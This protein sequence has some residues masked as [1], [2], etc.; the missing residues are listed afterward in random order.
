MR[1]ALEN[2]HLETR[3]RRL[4]HPLRVEH[5]GFMPEKTYWVDWV[6][7]VVAFSLVLSGSGELVVRNRSYKVRAPCVLCELPGMHFRYGPRDSWHEVFF[8]YDAACLP[9]LSQMGLVR[10]GRF[11]WSMPGARIKPKLGEL[12][13]L[14]LRLETPGTVDRIDRLSELIL[15]ETLL[16]QSE[17]GAVPEE[18]FGICRYLDEHHAE[19]VDFEKLARKFGFSFTTFRRAWRRHMPESPARFL[20][21]LRIKHACRLLCESERAIADVADE[22]GW[23]DPLY[24]SKAFH[25]YTGMTPRDYRRKYTLGAVERYS[26]P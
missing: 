2:V 24:F 12:A 10:D 4:P 3:P 18:L 1:A 8:K 19:A 17:E 25:R 26:T 6:F 23:D 20:L 5:L 22:L 16:G 14:C 15:A 13:E 7:D 11:L 9:L 21:G